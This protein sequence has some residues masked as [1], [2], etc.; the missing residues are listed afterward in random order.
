MSGPRRRGAKLR[1]QPFWLLVSITDVVSRRR[2]SPNRKTSGFLLTVRSSACSCVCS[3]RRLVIGG[4]ME[5]PYTNREGGSASPLSIVLTRKNV[6]FA[7]HDVGAQN[8]AI[9]ASLIE[10]CKLNSVNPLA[11]MTDVLP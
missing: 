2:P 10:T 3:N 5:A 11:W 4:T 6:L 9:V 7:G 8:W 1:F